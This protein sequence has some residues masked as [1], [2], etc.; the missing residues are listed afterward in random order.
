MAGSVHQEVEFGLGIH[1]EAGVHRQA[2][3][4]AD[5]T[6]AQLLDHIWKR[7]Q[8]YSREAVHALFNVFI[9]PGPPKL[10]LTMLCIAC[11]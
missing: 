7:L 9:S 6:V 10:H 2:L 3:Q 11:Q 8:V 5:E 1:G 4:P